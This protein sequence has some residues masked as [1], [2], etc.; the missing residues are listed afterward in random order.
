MTHAG[1][2]RSSS[3][4]A[5]GNL[6]AGCAGAVP[7]TAAAPQLCSFSHVFE[8]AISD[9]LQKTEL[10]ALSSVPVS[11]PAWSFSALGNG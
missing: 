4:A 2:G 5:I 10:Y 9:L 1:V 3:R 8:Y 6:S 7:H 11:I